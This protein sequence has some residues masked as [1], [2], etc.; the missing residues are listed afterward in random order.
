MMT[1]TNDPEVVD[2]I[3]KLGVADYI[4]KSDRFDEINARLS[5]ILTKYN[6]LLIE[7]MRKNFFSNSVNVNNRIVIT[8]NLPY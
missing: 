2:K 7:R 1:A 6:P 5:K 8:I 3:L 4:L